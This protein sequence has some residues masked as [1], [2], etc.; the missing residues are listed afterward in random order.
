MIEAGLLDNF[1]AFGVEPRCTNSNT[2]DMTGV[3]IGSLASS[4]LRSPIQQVEA[5]DFGKKAIH[6]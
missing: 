6:R 1:V 2:R 5:L 4:E 3:S